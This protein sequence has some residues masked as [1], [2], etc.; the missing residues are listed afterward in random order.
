GDTGETGDADGPTLPDTPYSYNDA[1]PPHFL[2]PIVGDFENTPADN[3]ITDAGATLGRV[4]FYDTALSK[5]ETVACGSCHQQGAG[6]SDPET[7]SEGFDGGHTGRNSMGLAN[8]RWAPSGRFF[9]D[10]RA[11]TLEE[12]VLQPIQNEVEMGLTLDELVARV[13]ERPYY[14]E[15][16]IDAFGDDE[17]TSDRVS[18]ALAQFVRAMASYRTRFD[19][20]VQLADTLGAPFPNFTPQENQ[21][22]AIFL[23]AQGGCAACH[24]AGPPPMPGGIF[25]NEA[26]LQPVE[27]INNGVDGGLDNADNGVGDVSGDPMDNGL[28]KSPSLRN[29]AVTAPYMHDGRFATLAEVVDFYS[30][31]VQPHVNLD[32]RLRDP[33]TNQPRRLNLSPAERQA[34]V[35]FLGTLTDEALLDDVRFSDPFAG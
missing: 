10:E 7:F 34:L 19:E 23:G 12:Q 20:G 6:F 15:L 11:A 16:F 9:W 30:D 14:D 2:T 31:D 33:Q 17:V 8:A 5:N 4:L 28:F 22:K 25:A 32:P 18:R 27:P 35:A 13:A 26:I 21:G 1:L 24:L 29:I 3:P